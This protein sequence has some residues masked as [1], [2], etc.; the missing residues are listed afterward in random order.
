MTN[1][2]INRVH[3]CFLFIN[4]NAISFK[5]RC[6]NGSLLFIRAEV[7]LKGAVFHIVFT[8][9]SQLPPPYRIDNMSEVPI[10]FYQSRTEDHQRCLLQPKQSGQCSMYTLRIF[11]PKFPTNFKFSSI[12]NFLHISFIKPKFPLKRKLPS[13]WKR[14][15]YQFYHFSISFL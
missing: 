1:V 6:S 11:V 14:C 4:H 7:M 13:I 5:L 3:S 12:L 10:L 2:S 9:A 8:D 15:S